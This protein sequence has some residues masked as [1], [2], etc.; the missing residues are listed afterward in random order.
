MDDW[1]LIFSNPLNSGV[2]ESGERLVNYKAGKAARDTQLG[3]DR[4]SLRKITSKALLLKRLADKL[5]FPAYFGN[6]WDA[7][8]E[9]MQDPVWNSCRGRVILFTGFEE[10]SH[11]LPAETLVLRRIMEQ[12]CRYWQKTAISLFV[13]ISP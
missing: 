3:F 5:S 2:F 7:V 12:S 13:I 1:S 6:N 10:L 8:S 9:I 4:I 11:R